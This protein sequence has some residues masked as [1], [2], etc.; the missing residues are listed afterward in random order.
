MSEEQAGI[1]Q[2]TLALLR[3]MDTKLDEVLLRL[4]T[5]ER[6]GA[7]KDEEIV[8]DRIAIIEL[9]QRVERIERRLELAD[10]TTA[11]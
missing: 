10:P 1:A 4:S 2:H 7:L 8:L 9:R 6:R 3:R 11:A 5:M